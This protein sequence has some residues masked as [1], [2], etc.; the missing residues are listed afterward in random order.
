MSEQKFNHCIFLD[1]L[2]LD[3]GDLDTGSLRELC[4]RFSS[5]DKTS[6]ALTAS[7]I[8]DADVIICNKV[9]IDAAVMRQCKQL[10]L[11][12]VA[13]TG[14]NNVDM[15][16]AERLGIRVAN[17]T[18]YATPSVVQ[19]V[20]AGLL[21]LIT[22]L[23][24]QR[25]LA[26]DGSWKSSSQFCVLPGAIGE[27]AGMTMG[28]IGYGELGRAVADV[29][30]CFG[31]QVQVSAR[32]GGKVSEGR[33]SFEEIL[34]SSDV[35]SLHCPLADNTR[36]LIDAAA[37]ARMRGHAILI[38]CAR[39]GIVDESA[40][41]EALLGGLLG[42]AVVDVLTT[43]PP[44]DGN[45]LLGERIPNLVLTPHT[46]WASVAARQRLIEG[47]AGNMRGFLSNKA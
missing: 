44:V 21:T 41:A 29:A 2:S 20:F 40:L 36:N 7:R 1:Y 5:F 31:M 17:V 28:I 26:V 39:G 8:A 6:P 11:L 22:R 23:D 42:G 25:Q 19:H 3:Q 12:C 9:V 14:T 33:L 37:L 4:D 35:I 34:S 16:E 45:P 38:N 27:L 47:I 46:A 24:H 43:E 32:P 13:A 10:R 18:G 30:S 15:D